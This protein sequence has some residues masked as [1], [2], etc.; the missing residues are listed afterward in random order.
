M[1]IWKRILVA[2]AVAL[3]AA[4]TLTAA[5]RKAVIPVHGLDCQA[6]ANGLAA[7]LKSLKGVKAA[8]VNLK[9]GQATVTYDD[10]VI[11]LGDINKQIEANGFSTKPEE[12]GKK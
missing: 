3:F 2:A 1:Q 5:E 7:S 10:R 12:K 4:A 11:S 9:T 6:C 8:E